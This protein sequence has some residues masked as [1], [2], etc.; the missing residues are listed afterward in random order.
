MGKDI[1]IRKLPQV[2]WRN[3]NKRGCFTH[4]DTHARKHKHKHDTCALLR[5][6]SESE[7]DVQ[8][9]HV[10]CG[11]I[12]FS[13]FVLHRQAQHC[14]KGGWSRLLGKNNPLHIMASA[15]DKIL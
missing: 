15:M 9:A 2:S 6:K 4:T 11:I 5:G 8:G 10:E 1:Q 3:K 7:V 12:P 14:K 13:G